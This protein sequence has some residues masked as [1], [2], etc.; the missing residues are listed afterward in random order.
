MKRPLFTAIAIL[1]MS[2]GIAVALLLALYVHFEWTYDAHHE[3]A[4]RIYRVLIDKSG[5]GG[6]VQTLALPPPMVAVTAN[7]EMPQV[8]EAVRIGR[9]EDARFTTQRG[10]P[11]R[12]DVLYADPSFFNIFTYDVLHGAQRALSKPDGAVLTVS[13][14]QN[15][16]GR[17]NVIGEHVSVRVGDSVLN[18]RVGAVVADPPSNSSVLFD[19]MAPMASA[20]STYMPLVRDVLFRSWDVSGLRTYMRLTETSS[21]SSVAAGLQAM[22]ESRSG[23]SE[24]QIRLQPLRDVHFATTVNGGLSAP[25]TPYFSLVLAGVAFVI[26]VAGCVNFVSLS[27]AQVGERAREVGVRKSLGSSPAQI[28]RNF[29]CESLLLAAV[30]TGL[31]SATAFV[32]LPSFQSLTG[33]TVAI[34][35]IPL[36]ILVPGLVAFAGALGIIIGAYP[37]RVLAFLSP[38]DILRGKRTDQ[39]HGVTVKGLL[40]LQFSIAIALVAGT[41]ATHDHIQFVTSKDLGFEAERLLAVYGD[42]VNRQYKTLQSEVRRLSSVQDVTGAMFEYGVLGVRSAVKSKGDQVFTAF[43][44]PIEHNFPEVLGAHWHA[45]SGF[46]QTGGSGDGVLVN[47]AF[48]QQYGW[49]DPVGRTISFDGPGFHSSIENP[50]IRGVLRNIHYESLHH[51]VE[52]MIFPRIES[53]G[54]PSALFLR[55]DDSRTLD[56]AVRDVLSIWQTLS[57]DSFQYEFLSSNVEAQYRAER[58]WR[59]MITIGASIALGI[60]ALGLIGLI[61]LVIRQRTKE[62]GIRRTMGA[63]PASVFLLLVRQPITLIL[64][65]ACVSLPLTYIGIRQWLQG[66]AFTDGVSALSLAL[67][68]A[69]VLL[70]VAATV[71]AAVARL[72]QASPVNAIRQS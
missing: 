18:L 50:T 39:E 71:S 44:H 2:G 65:A 11:R 40:V 41:L 64:I 37:A 52:P 63:T 36:W 66:F 17:A 69:I 68:V 4:E 32:L 23:K 61:Q 67:S 16:F 49:E 72:M 47:E 25:S 57:S 33:R 19:V 34:D 55:L 30:S 48:A 1:S 13:T 53:V 43:I 7:D 31:G 35:A 38:S 6:T 14:A 46:T 29:W 5:P 62:I 70:V 15:L 3:H 60:A 42:D 8:E 24:N 54:A 45:G 12:G 28:A 58:R 22:Y 27:L 59:T 26:L 56:Q 10:D 20:E 9:F 51:R 21:V